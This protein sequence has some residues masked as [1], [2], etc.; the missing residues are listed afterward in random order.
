V[1]RLVQAQEHLIQAVQLLT[2][3]HKEFPTG[4]VRYITNELNSIVGVEN[5]WYLTDSLEDTIRILEDATRD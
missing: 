2:E 4:S 3:Y 1:D 5:T